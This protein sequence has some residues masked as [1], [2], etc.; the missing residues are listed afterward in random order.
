MD[1]SEAASSIIKQVITTYETKPQAKQILFSLVGEDFVSTHYNSNVEYQPHLL[2]VP[3][4]LP[5]V[6]IAL[7]QEFT[8]ILCTAISAATT[9]PKHPI[10][11]SDA[12]M[13]Y[14]AMVG[15]VY[16][17]AM[18]EESR[19]MAATA[20]RKD[21][22]LKR[23]H[24]SKRSTNRSEGETGGGTGR[25]ASELLTLGISALILGNGFAV[26]DNEIKKN[27]RHHSLTGNE[28][29]LNGPTATGNSNSSGSGESPSKNE[30]SSSVFGGTSSG[31]NET[32]VV[33]NVHEARMA[34]TH[35]HHSDLLAYI[36]GTSLVTNK[37]EWSSMFQKESRG[38]LKVVIGR[39]VPVTLRRFILKW[40]IFNPEHVALT[41]T[42]IRRNMAIDKLINPTVS[43]IENL[44]LRSTTQTF[45]DA[46]R[47]FNSPRLKTSVLAL[48]N[49]YYTYSGSQHPSHVSLAV[50]LLM[51]FSNQPKQG[52]YVVSM[53]HLM[54]DI[55]PGGGPSRKDALIVARRVVDTLAEADPELFLHLSEL[56]N[57]ARHYQQTL[58]FGS[59]SE[60]SELAIFIKPWVETCLVGFVRRDAV[61][62]I[63][64]Q[65]F[66][67]GWSTNFEKFCIDVLSIIKI[68][69]MEVKSAPELKRAM[70]L[71]PRRVH[72][73]NLREIFAK[74]T[75]QFPNDATLI[76][77]WNEPPLKIL[78][79]RIEPKSIDLER[80]ERLL[81]ITGGA[82]E[83]RRHAD[84]EARKNDIDTKRDTKSM[85]VCC[86]K[87]MLEKA[88]ELLE[89][90]NIEVNDTTEEGKSFLYIA[91]ENSHLTIVQLLLSMDGIDPDLGMESTGV[92]PLMAAVIGANTLEEGYKMKQPD[93]TTAVIV[94]LCNAGAD[95]NAKAKRTILRPTTMLTSLQRER[96]VGKGEQQQQQQ[97]FEKGGSGGSGDKGTLANVDSLDVSV[98]AQRAQPKDL[99]MMLT[100]VPRGSTALHAAV[101]CAC[102]SGTRYFCHPQLVQVLLA[103][104]ANPTLININEQTCK[105]ILTESNVDAKLAKGVLSALN[106]C[107]TSSGGASQDAAFVPGI[108]QSML[109]SA[110]TLRAGV[111]TGQLSQ[112]KRVLKSMDNDRVG[113]VCIS[114]STPFRHTLQH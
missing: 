52:P 57:R 66:L 94:A 28:D 26:D 14:K 69:L 48:L 88:K 80:I 45:A 31:S 19:L 101:A 108:D 59:T 42:V 11:S 86:K 13:A 76:E 105:Q 82:N 114:Q 8:S 15:R 110:D 4:M 22:R 84:L 5:D 25:S 6:R 33:S 43:T 20:V 70:V 103:C 72:T 111:R 10:N 102:L 71:L 40:R 73:R 51:A 92:T 60:F 98:A 65:C 29:D 53:F 63:W 100:L 95:I 37:V 23:R 21:H 79:G 54:L 30:K 35:S 49:Q 55:L 39:C 99:E 75:Q 3:Y 17:S 97:Q 62:F 109:R 38:L 9:D 89:D 56:V 41:S 27:M 104:G 96:I 91:A 16:G 74:R 18:T 46:L 81:S 61:L 107:G 36:D 2:E 87:G 12:F 58:D 47:D 50:P 106:A 77:Y 90:I 112:V 113:Y 85:A 7:E 32:E 24:D 78:S 34:P 93:E 67:T 68:K 83:L 44:L 64:D 1:L